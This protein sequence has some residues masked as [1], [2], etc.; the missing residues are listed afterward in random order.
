M[1]LP[2]LVVLK[3]WYPDSK[4]NLG[5]NYK[6]KI[7]GL[8]PRPSESETL[9]VWPKSPWCVQQARWFW[10]QVKSENNYPVSSLHHKEKG[11]GGGCEKEGIRIFQSSSMEREICWDLGLKLRWEIRTIHLS[12]M[13]TCLRK[14]MEKSKIWKFWVLVLTSPSRSRVD[15]K[16][17]PSKWVI[18]FTSSFKLHLLGL[19]AEEASQGWQMTW[20]KQTKGD[21]TKNPTHQLF[22]LQCR[23]CSH[24]PSNFK[25]FLLLAQTFRV[26]ENDK[27]WMLIFVLRTQKKQ[28][29]TKAGGTQDLS[30]KLNL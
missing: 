12:R 10:H 3:V 14:A 30:S 24:L 18:S 26:P 25:H 15:T 23:Q 6:C 22:N 9:G 27:L 1:G 29:K 11:E 17:A 5:I 2:R 21:I 7:S 19:K 28:N 4:Y 16:M 8:T 20:R 13:H